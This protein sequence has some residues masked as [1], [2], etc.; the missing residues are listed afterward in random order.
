MYPVILN[1]I[2]TDSA[3]GDG[4]EGA[5]VLRTE[6]RVLRCSRLLNMRIRYIFPPLNLKQACHS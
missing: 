2:L 4:L 5:N 6:Y 1:L 3:A